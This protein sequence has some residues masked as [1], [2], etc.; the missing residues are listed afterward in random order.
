[1]GYARPGCRISGGSVTVAGRDMVQLS[2][3][4][5]AKI[6]GTKI[7]YVPQSAA[8]AFNPAQKIIDQV[9]EV[10]RIHDL[11]PP[12][13][14]RRRAV[15]LFKALSLPNPKPSASVIR[16]RFPAASFNVSPPPWR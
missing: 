8:A 3:M 4:E 13:E 1:M 7:S 10:T 6:R 5:R 16:T 15:E 2:E 9:I 11:M 12:Q 14:A